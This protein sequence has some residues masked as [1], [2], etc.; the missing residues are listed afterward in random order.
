MPDIKEYHVDTISSFKV[1][2]SVKAESAQ[3][4]MDIFN[5]SHN[6]DLE[7]ID[8]FCLG[9]VISDIRIAGMALDISPNIIAEWLDSE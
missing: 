2:Y 8:Q 3:S 9:E 7:M 4:A 6:V 5:E 1:R